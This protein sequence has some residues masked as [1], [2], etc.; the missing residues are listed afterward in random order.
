MAY[1]N[2]RGLA[3]LWDRI[4]QTFGRRTQSAGSQSLNGTVLALV[5]IDGNTLSTV[6]FSSAISSAVSSGTSGLVTKDEANTQYGNGLSLSGKKL[7]LVNSK[8][9]TIS[10]VTLP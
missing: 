7:S 10:S 3:S 2:S 6:D 9:N 5:A 1:L 8:G 4:S